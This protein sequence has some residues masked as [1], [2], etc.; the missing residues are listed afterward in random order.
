MPTRQ[1][2][3]YDIELYTDAAGEHRWRMTDRRNG[4]IVAASTEGYKNKSD[5]EANL[6]V[7]TGWTA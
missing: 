7:V 4:E 3:N 2:S 1:R 6:Y 5:C